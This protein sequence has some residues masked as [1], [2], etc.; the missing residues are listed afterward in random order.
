MGK[1]ILT[2]TAGA[3]ISAFALQGVATATESHGEA[4]HELFNFIDTNGDGNISV[5]EMT[6]AH[7]A[8]DADGNG[9]VSPVE[10]STAP[11]KENKG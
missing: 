10:F 11:Q 6:A 7:K 9:E 4:H 1:L 8:M 5:D 3:M 2:L